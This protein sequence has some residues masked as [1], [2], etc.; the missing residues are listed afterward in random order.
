MKDF[1]TNL[2]KT[3]YKYLIYLVLIGI[4]SSFIIE[5]ILLLIF[6][7][8]YG[9]LSELKGQILSMCGLSWWGGMDYSNYIF[10][11][12]PGDCN[13]ITTT[14]WTGTP[15]LLGMG[16]ILIGFIRKK[17]LDI[18]LQYNDIRMTLIYFFGVIFLC[19]VYRVLVGYNRDFQIFP[20]G[21][22]YSVN[23]VVVSLRMFQRK[24]N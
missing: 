9:G 5:P 4:T 20:D 1:L 15:I 11:P 13:Y 14:F 3:D 6:S 16:S 19:S 23:L 24:E 21:I 2:E 22:I 18:E 12:S 10:K 7:I 8:P 17:S